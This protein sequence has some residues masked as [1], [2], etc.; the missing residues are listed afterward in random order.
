MMKCSVPKNVFRGKFKFLK[1][2]INRE[3]W[4]TLQM[5]LSFSSLFASSFTNRVTSVIN[6][7]HNPRICSVEAN[8]NANTIDRGNTLHKPPSINSN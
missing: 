6:A 1:K 8:Q 3:I 2:Q 5:L 7:Y 4:K